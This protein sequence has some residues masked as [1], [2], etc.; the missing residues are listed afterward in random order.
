MVGVAQVW[1]CLLPRARLGG[2]MACRGADEKCCVVVV[3]VCVLHVSDNDINDII[4][5]ISQSDLTNISVWI[6]TRPYCMVLAHLANV[7]LE[8]R[9]SSMVPPLIVLI[10]VTTGA[11]LVDWRLS[12]LG[13]STGV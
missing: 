4:D 13:F 11:R 9:R 3:R 1:H 7:R 10:R 6:L 8:V 5:N 2:E 12:R